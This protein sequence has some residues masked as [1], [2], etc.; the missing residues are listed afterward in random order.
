LLLEQLSLDEWAKPSTL[1]SGRSRSD[2][3]WQSTAK[4]TEREVEGSQR[5]EVSTVGVKISGLGV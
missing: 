1:I 3:T 5:G 2:V 4:F